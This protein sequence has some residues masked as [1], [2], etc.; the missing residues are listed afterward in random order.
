MWNK[1]MG[2]GPRCHQLPT[3]YASAD[4]RSV[5]ALPPGRNLG[6]R[7]AHVDLGQVD[8]RG[9]V[10][11]SRYKSGSG[12]SPPPSVWF[13]SNYFLKRFLIIQKIVTKK[14]DTGGDRREEPTKKSCFGGTT[15]R[16][17]P[18]FGGSFFL[19]IF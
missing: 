3:G 19:D 6:V 1:D 17:G 7:S 10:L 11:R 4:G 12:V 13:F 18:C 2:W 16:W 8:T 5:V 15:M 9:Q 14:P